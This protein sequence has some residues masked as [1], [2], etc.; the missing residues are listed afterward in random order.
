M[1]SSATHFIIGAALALPA[2]K[3]RELTSMLPKWA[4]PVT[5]GVLATIPDLDLAGRRALGIPNTSVFAHRG[6]FHS[7]FFLLLFAALLAAAVARNYSPKAFA[8]LWFVWGGCLVTHPLLDAMTDGGRGVMLLLP[9]TEARFFFLWRPLHTAL[10][11]TGNLLSRALIIR[12]SEIPFCLGAIAIGISG[13]LARIMPRVR[14]RRM[15][16]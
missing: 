7:P 5:S 12:R 6:F 13:F 3:C 14:E 15:E 9:F 11:G 10:G 1:S 16:Q 4:I 2:V 8:W